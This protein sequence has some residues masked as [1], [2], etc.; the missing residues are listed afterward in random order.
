MIMYEPLFRTMKERGE[1]GYSLRFKYGFSSNIYWRITRGEAIT[2][3]TIEVLCEILE[4][5]VVDII[6]YV[7]DE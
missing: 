4:C 2:T 5:D 3:K 6:E 7:P 1:T